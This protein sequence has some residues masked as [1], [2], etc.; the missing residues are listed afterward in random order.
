MHDLFSFKPIQFFRSNSYHRV[1][2][3][4]Y[5]LGPLIITSGQKEG[6][7]GGYIHYPLLLYIS[8]NF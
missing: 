8:S 2:D 1:V 6:G 3:N 4:H 5:F 7:A